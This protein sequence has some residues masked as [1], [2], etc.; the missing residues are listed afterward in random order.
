MIMEIAGQ[1]PVL[2][3]SNH[4]CAD[5]ILIPGIVSIKINAALQ[6]VSLLLQM[7]FKLKGKSVDKAFKQ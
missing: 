7:A 3:G 2:S 4:V 6:Y 5:T 1:S